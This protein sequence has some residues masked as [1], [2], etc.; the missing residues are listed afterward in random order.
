MNTI[1]IIGSLGLVV[2][3]AIVTVIALKQEERKMKEY[4]TDVFSYQDELKRSHEYEE[5]SIK[6]VVPIQLWMYGIGLVVSIVL[7]IAFA[8]YY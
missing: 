7:I 8:I 3:A 5:N 4:Q 1:L 6:N 2:V